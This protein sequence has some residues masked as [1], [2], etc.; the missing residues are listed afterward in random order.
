M[1]ASV[2][3]LSPAA[4]ELVNDVALR[5]GFSVDATLSMLDALVRGGGSM[6]QFNH[7]EFSGPGQSMRGGM[8]MV[9]DMFNGQLKGRIDALCLELSNLLAREPHLVRTDRSQSQ[10][11]GIDSGVVSSI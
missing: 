10:G 6:A 2:R 8:T 4:R 7:P 11:E 5:H 9:S 1:S 3:L